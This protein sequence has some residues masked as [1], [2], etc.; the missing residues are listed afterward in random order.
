[1]TTGSRCGILPLLKT[2]A[3]ALSRPDY[4]EVICGASLPGDGDNRMERQMEMARFS[5]TN[6]TREQLVEMSEYLVQGLGTS[7]GVPLTCF[8]RDFVE[9]E[10]STSTVQGAVG[11][12]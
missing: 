3:I 5:R 6:T 2:R 8:K 7:L 10:S 9:G 12:F 4:R 11:F 1:M